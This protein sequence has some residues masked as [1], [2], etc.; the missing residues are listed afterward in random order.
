MIGVQR[1]KLGAGLGERAADIML[2]MPF[3]GDDLTEEPLQRRR[4]GDQRRVERRGLPVVE[5]VA[6]VEDD[7]RGANR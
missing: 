6:D 4:I 7:G 2:V 1:R 3:L 5:D